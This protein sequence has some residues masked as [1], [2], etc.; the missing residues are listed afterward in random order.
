MH[1]SLDRE[2]PWDSWM[3]SQSTT[4]QPGRDDLELRGHS[5]S[6]SIRI[7]LTMMICSK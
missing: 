5:T 7:I 4:C 1:A 6:I 3:D 2:R